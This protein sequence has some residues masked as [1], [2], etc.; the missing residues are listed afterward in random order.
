LNARANRLAHLLRRWGVGSGV[1]V[2]VC[3]ERSPEMVVGLL[4]ALKAGGAYVPLDPAYPRDRLAFLLTDARVPVLLTQERL[5]TTLA[6]LQPQE[7]GAPTPRI[8]CLDGR[9]GDLDGESAE[10][11]FPLGS[12]DELAYVIY[13]SGSTGRPKGAMN[14]HRAICNRLLWLQ[15]VD[16]LTAEDR[17]F[18]KTPFSFDI[19]VW[20]FFWPLATGARLVL[21][22][23]GGH[24]DPDYLVRLITQAGITTVHFVPSML[25]VFL[26]A[27]GVESCASLRRVIC[28]GEALTAQLARR[29]FARFPAGAAPVLYNLYGPT[30]AA[31]EVTAWRCEPESQLAAVPIGRPIANTQA[32]VLDAHLGAM[33]IGVPGELYLG[34]VQLAR[35][36][37]DRPDLTA[38]RFLPDP[39]AAAESAGA[40]L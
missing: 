40:R 20:E 27:R 24:Q 34:G 14:S 33:P 17:V 11:P 38:E 8:L 10:N 16:G 32:L 22:R 12:A 4:A 39:F 23:P 3:L 21:A 31:V 13:T 25:Q 9:Q 26:E 5:L 6:T 30:E 15:A 29:F 2:G 7:P 36:Y 37:L 19:S 1:R 35:G 28:S 18:Q